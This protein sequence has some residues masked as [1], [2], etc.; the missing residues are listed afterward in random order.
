M[1]FCIVYIGLYIYSR[2][3]SINHVGHVLNDYFNR[4]NPHWRRRCKI[5]ITQKN[6]CLT[7]GSTHITK[8]FLQVMCELRLAQLKRAKT[9]STNERGGPSLYDCQ[10]MRSRRKSLVLRAFRV[11]LYLKKGVANP[12]FI[13]LWHC[14]DNNFHILNVVIVKPSLYLFV[15]LSDANTCFELL[16]SKCRNNVCNNNKLS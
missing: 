14:I 3:D 11:T 16:K 7:S 13:G 1:H 10:M 2:F 5:I 12:W 9:L 8:L 15:Y 4:S 6:M